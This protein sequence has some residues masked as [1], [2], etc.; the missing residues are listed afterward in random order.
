MKIVIICT[1]Y[2][3][4]QDGIGHYAYNLSKELGKINEIE[5]EI[6]SG[7]TEKFDKISKIKSKVMIE[8]I[9]NFVKNNRS[10]IDTNT[11]FLIEYPFLEWNPL[12]L[13]SLLKLRRLCKNNRSKVIISIHEYKRVARLRKVFTDILISISDYIMVSDIETYKILKKK[14]KPIL[15]RDIP[16]NIPITEKKEKEKNLFCYFGLINKSKCFNEMIN[17]W[18]LFNKDGKYKLNIYSS[19]D[20]E[21]NEMEKFNIRYFKN[22]EDEELS[23]ELWKCKY[24]V[25]PIK[26]GIDLNNGSLKAVA[27]HECLPIGIFSNESLSDIGINIEDNFYT[28]ENIAVA[29]GKPINLSDKQYKFKVDKLAKFG[30]KYSFK[31]NAQVIINFITQRKE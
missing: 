21:I 7:N 15:I 5:V 8:S 30:N 11:Y 12:V 3:S 28:E 20:I 31:N 13:S 25:L 16:S 10:N 26:P 27:Q 19:T 1:N 14:S 24:C 18:K 6:I 23:K 22:L 2:S 29:L 4:N 9:N 17:A